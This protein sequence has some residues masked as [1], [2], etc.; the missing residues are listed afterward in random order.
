MNHQTF[1]TRLLALLAADAS[2]RTPP[3][4]TLPGQPANGGTAPS[5]PAL[6]WRSPIRW[7]HE[8]SERRP[9]GNKPMPTD[10]DPPYTRD[11]LQRMDSKFVN[12][13][14]LALAAGFEHRAAAEA[15]SER[16]R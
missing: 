10:G 13:L 15:V 7:D 14:E 16:L 5:P 12:R 3:R 4:P 11:Q 2:K 8:P 6:V 1:L 9:V